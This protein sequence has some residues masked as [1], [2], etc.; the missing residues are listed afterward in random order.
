[1]TAAAAWVGSKLMQPSLELHQPWMEV[2]YAAYADGEAL[3]GW[4]NATLS[5]SAPTAFEANDALERLAREIQARLAGAEIAH[6][7]MTFSP[8]GGLNDLAVVNLVRSDF[9]PELALRLEQPVSAGQLILNLRGEAAPETL[10]A[11]VEAAAQ[12][13]GRQVPGLVAR[14]DHLE[15]FRPEKPQPTHRVLAPV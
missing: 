4:L 7:K 3:L 2:D 8:E 13:L 15:H 14:I 6:L 12:E 10:K 1:M 11:A 5:L 9:V